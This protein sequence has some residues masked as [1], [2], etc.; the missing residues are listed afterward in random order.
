[1]EELYR[2]CLTEDG[3]NILQL[4]EHILLPPENVADLKVKLRL[5]LMQFFDYSI[6]NREMIL[7]IS[8]DVNSKMAMESIH[9]IFRII[10]EKLSAFFQSAIDQKIVRPDLEA[11]SLC[12][13][14]VQ[15]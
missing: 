15:P 8:K 4:M 5:F 3:T 7:M 1:K 14:V 2:A 10:P 9:K 6:N 13:L 11:S 12:D